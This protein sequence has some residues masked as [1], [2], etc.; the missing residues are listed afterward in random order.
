M[1][2]H[3]GSFPAPSQQTGRSILIVD[4]SVSFR[5][6]LAA[7]LRAGGWRVVGEV[8]DAA[9][10]LRLCRSSHTDVALIDVGL[11]GVDGVTLARLLAVEAHPPAIVLMSADDLTIAQARLA[12]VAVRGVAKKAHLTMEVLDALLQV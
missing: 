3:L 4:D 5:S 12:E 2:E 8:A 7:R 9:S 6:R 1:V 11:P 10:A